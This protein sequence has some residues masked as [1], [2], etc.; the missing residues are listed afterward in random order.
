MQ[1]SIYRNFIAELLTS[2]SA[3]ARDN[4]GKVSGTT[5]EGDPNQVLT[6]A[7]LSIGQLMIDEITRHFSGHN[8][9][10]EEAGLVDKGSV[11][12]WVVDPIDG[13]SNFAAGVPLFGIMLGLLEGGTPIAGGI[14]LPALNMICV[15]EK[16]A[17]AWCGNERMSVS[18]GVDLQNSL[19]AYGMDSDPRN[20]EAAKVECARLEKLVPR[21]RNLR[22]SNSAFDVVMV[23]QGKY[24]GILNRTSRIWD[25][26]APQM[27][28][29]EAG[30][31]FTSFDGKPSD[32]TKPLSRAGDNFTFCAAEP[33][34]HRELQ[35]LLAPAQATDQS[36]Q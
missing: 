17:G 32:Y 1:E 7:D 26:V 16:G 8:I 25:N 33:G 30:G 15:A 34:V 6:A 11:Y 12:T 3:V 21:I 14:A 36:P 31:I 2:S 27:M 20:P 5:K 13:T 19:I 24:G 28:V 29:E 35:V 4:F 9:I 18:H 10:D 23:A 22:T